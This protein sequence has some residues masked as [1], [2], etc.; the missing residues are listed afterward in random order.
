M[1]TAGSTNQRASGNVIGGHKATISNPNT[2]EE[3]K[4]HSREMLEQLEGKTTTTSSGVE[5]EG[6]NEGNVVGGY[7][8]ALKN[9]KVSEEAKERAENVLEELGADH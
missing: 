6:K 7:K 9:P 2:S 4:Q 1:D 5:L 8:A 3:A